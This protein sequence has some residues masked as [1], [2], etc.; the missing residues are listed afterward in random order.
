[1]ARTADRKLAIAKR[2]FERATKVHGLG[3]ADLVFDPL[4]LPISTGMESDRRSALERLFADPALL[5]AHRAMLPQAPPRKPG[6]IDVAHVVALAKLDDC[7]TLHQVEAALTRAELMAL[8]ADARGLDRLAALE[9]GQ[10][11]LKSMK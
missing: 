1:M 9:R 7:A 10:P 2:A 6:E 3:P 5:A 4:V 8:L 11:A